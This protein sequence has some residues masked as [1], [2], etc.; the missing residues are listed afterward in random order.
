[1]AVYRRG[2]SWVADYRIGGRTG[3][4]VRKAAPTRELAKAHERDAK[5]K[6]FRG[7]VLE[8][9]QEKIRLSELVR[10]YNELHENGN[11]LS[12]RT[13]NG[14]VFERLK[15]ALGN[16]I[17][18]EISERDLDQYKANRLKVVKPATVNLELRVIRSL[19]NRAK[20]WG[21]LKNSPARR[22]RSLRLEQ[23]EP[24]FLTVEEGRCLS[25]VA[26]GQMKTFIVV[27]LNTGLRKGELFALKWS[28]ID[29]AK[30]ELRVRKSKGKRFRVVL[31]NHTSLEALRTQPRHITSRLIFYNSNGT[32]WKDVR[33]SFR[34]A[35]TH[36]K[37]PRIRIHDLRHSFVSNLVAAG[38]DLRAVQELAGHANIATTM[39]YAHLSPER[40]RES[41]AALEG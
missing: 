39:K 18:Q 4:R 13:R 15:D 23:K 19:F 31:L 21:V 5:V 14:Y 30:A 7:D 2:K 38:V 8:V 36:A 24:H 9:A 41:V 3:R 16:P 26:T 28:D 34:A 27:A 25:R 29:I 17:L 37:L 22:V 35:L 33:G 12:T 40:L 10:R 1:M 6:E 11:A 20:E 32:A